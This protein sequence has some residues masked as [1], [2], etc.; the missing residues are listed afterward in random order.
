MDADFRFLAVFTMKR[1]RAIETDVSLFC[2]RRTRWH[3][4]KLLRPCF[5]LNLILLL[6]W[7][8]SWQYMVVFSVSRVQYYR[9]TLSLRCKM[10]FR[11]TTAVVLPSHCTKITPF[12]SF[13]CKDLHSCQTLVEVSHQNHLRQTEVS[14]MHRYQLCLKRMGT[15]WMMM[16]FWWS[17]SPP[18]R[19]RKWCMTRI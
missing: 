17:R 4:A 2:C 12:I 10:N 13:D 11:L 7:H 3:S 6:F 18:R 19:A 5:V 15:L 16:T 8:L 14:P 9:K 1:L